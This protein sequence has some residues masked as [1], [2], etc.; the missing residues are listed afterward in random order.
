MND[1]MHILILE[2]LPADAEL[3]AREVRHLFPRSEFL[4]VERRDEFLKALTSFGP[5]IILSNYKLP[6]FAGIRALKL[7][8]AHLPDTPFIIV[9]DS[10]DEDT[11]VQCM[12][13]GAWDYIVKER[14]KRLGPAV[15]NA[16]AQKRLRLEQKL[17]M[18]TSRRWKRMF[19]KARFGLAHINVTENTFIEIN[20]AFARERGY[21]PEELKNRP[22]TDIHAPEVRD[23]L[24]QQ[25]PQ[26]DIKGHAVF[27]S[28]HLRK[29]G[30]RFP[31]LMTVTTIK[32]D[33]G[34][35]VSR[36]AQALDITQR[37][38]ADQAQAEEA[39]QRKILIEQ[40][41]DGIVILDQNGNIYE[42]NKRFGEMLGYP[43]EELRR[44]HVWE[45]DTQLPRAQ[46]LEMIRAV[47]ET[48]D[49]FETRHR[50]RDGSYI[51]VEISTNG[52]MVDGRKLIFCVCR[53]ISRR[54]QVHEALRNSEALFRNLFE[55]HAA[56]K[57]IIDPGTGAIIDANQAAADFYGWSRDQLKGM[58]LHEINPLS[59]EEIKAEIEKVRT[60]KRVH[61]E[62]RH[63]RADGSVRDVEVFSSMIE[64]KGKEI[65]HS[66]V[67]DI[68][69][70]NQAEAALRSSEANLRKIQD[71]LNA[72]QRLAKLGGWEYDPQTRQMTW[73]DEV[74]RIY[75]LPK[76]CDH[77]PAGRD[78]ALYAPEDRKKIAEAFQRALDEGEPYD[79]ELQLINARRDKIWVRT[80]GQV[81]RR[82]GQIV[83]VFGNLMDITERRGAQAERER[84]TA[85]VNQVGDSIFITDPE[86][87]IQYANPAFETVTGYSRQEAIGQNPRFLK[88]GKHPPAFYHNLWSTISSGRT[89]KGR[90][91]NKRKD[92]TLYTEA[93]TISPVRDPT[94]KI[95]NYVAVKRDITDHL[96]LEAQ[97]QQ[98][99]KMESVGRLAGGVAHDYNNILSVILGYTELALDRVAPS[100]PLRND[101]EQI[102]KAA[103][104]SRDITRQLLAFA[105]KQT[106]APQILDLN[107]TVESMLKIMRRLIGE[108]IDLAWLPGSGIWPVKMDPTQVDQILANLCVNARDAIAGVGKFTIET[109]TVILDKSYCEN[110]AG[111][112]PGE[113][114]QLALSDD[115]CGMDKETLD[116]IF[117]PFFT[118]KELG[119]GTGLGLATVYGIVKQNNG[120]ISV[121]SEPGNGTAFKIYLPRH[122]Q[123]PTD[124]MAETTEE[125]SRGRGETVLVVEDDDSIL[126]L[127]ERILKN[128]G[129]TVLTAR[130]PGKAMGIA[131]QHN[132]KIHLLIT[133]VVMPEMN[134]RALAGQMQSLDPHLKCLFMSGYTADAI[135]HRGVLEKGLNFIQKP[136]SI[137]DLATIIRNVIDKAAR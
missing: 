104:R 90:I 122:S 112:V 114:V 24:K 40:S 42:A 4:R 106:I 101:L 5:D 64:V 119:K 70:R 81:E 96:R 82:D 111:S 58:R 123:M 41:R 83:R 48:G 23:A 16:L 31:V 95:V 12:K 8:Q 35:P 102:F 65:L 73:T 134:G 17:A 32:D 76:N 33:Q 56:V 22:V 71:L 100:D 68:T 13:A 51:D 125:I 92:R 87:T 107:A 6:Q 120:F 133:D 99:Q 26:I 132:G 43:P 20:A 36:V 47:D 19:E 129:Y 117:E 131:E 50:R 118:T 105:R 80:I 52:A 21:T 130:T 37:R 27:E 62:F 11:A 103:E 18:E 30:S 72:T 135:V 108:D 126:Q 39:I 1:V 2:H 121:Y 44:L 86:G 127:T 97:L 38:Q 74:Y 59:A 54:K 110:H 45:W 25:L 77:G 128:L 93:V 60:R 14:I 66:I 34:R 9:T 7:A 84:L 69:D 88:S 46:L 10:I 115:G 94:G 136:F 124:G 49:H 75:G 67:H 116:N 28:V 109:G 98:A 57:L 3:D 137:K 29:D 63:R 53:D 55:R 79:L 78:M 91:I 85:A 61:F 15:R 89:W 113:Y